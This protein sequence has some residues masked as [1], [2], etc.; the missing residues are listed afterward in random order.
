MQS[1]ENE[2]IV[3]FEIDDATN[4][5]SKFREECDM[6][7]DGNP[8]CDLLIS[9]SNQEDNV[10]FCLVEVKGSS[11]SNR[12]TL[13]ANLNEASGQIANTYSHCQRKL[14]EEIKGY[15]GNYKIHWACCIVTNQMGHGSTH[16][17]NQK[18]VREI[19]KEL[20]QIPSAIINADG[21]IVAR[22]GRLMGSD[23]DE[24]IGDFLRAIASRGS[25]PMGKTR[26]NKRR[27]RGS[28]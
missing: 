11:S 23:I 12:Q 17:P 9:Y 1:L 27:K 22:D 16:T 2:R 21:L 5:C 28:Y 26:G 15:R 25:I 24:T 6:K 20:P 14:E 19:R 4:E 8:I 3:F 18:L 13:E 10:W 7:D